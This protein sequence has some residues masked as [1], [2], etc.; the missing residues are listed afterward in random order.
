MSSV[1]LASNVGFVSVNSISPTTTPVIPQSF[2]Q[3]MTITNQ[4][5][6]TSQLTSDG[7]YRVYTIAGDTV[8]DAPIDVT[9]TIYSVTPI[10]I[11]Y[12]CVGAGGSSPA[13]PSVAY[14]VLGGPGGGACLQGSYNLTE[15]YVE[16]QILLRV[17]QKNIGTIYSYSNPNTVLT[18]PNT[19]ILAG[20]GGGG[21]GD[22]N[23]INGSSSR[24]G[25]SNRTSH[26]SVSIFP[27]S[28]SPPGY[29]GGNGSGGF[30]GAGGGAGGAGGSTY[31][32]PTVA[33]GIRGGDGAT[34]LPSIRGIHNIYR[35]QK[36]CAGGQGA[37]EVNQT[38]SAYTRTGESG[39]GIFGCGGG[40]NASY[41]PNV[42][43]GQPGC[44]IF[45]ISVADFPG[46]PT[47]I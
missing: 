7:L 17:L 39:V 6:V 31:S 20:V 32:Y 25:R 10:T 40:A 44:I 26:S 23:G 1:Y 46:L 36:F 19:T 16:K 38:I 13:I 8:N 11:Y 22:G 43:P 4:P 18:F 33:E 30:S 45:A 42:N 41:T 14:N 47:Y 12:V 35:N 34:V 21:S 28:P 2:T 5:K 24:G 37:S 9:V 27:A 3:T 15:S 29:S